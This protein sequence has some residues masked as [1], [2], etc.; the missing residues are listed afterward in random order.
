MLTHFDLVN[1]LRDVNND[2]AFYYFQTAKNL[3]AG[4]FSTFDDGITR[5]NGYH[6]LWLLLITPFYWV[7]DPEAALFGIKAFEIMLVA[8]GVAL[9]VLAA[10]I[11][12]LPWMLLFALLPLL[13]QHRALYHGLEAAAAL[14]MLGLLFLALSLFSRN[15]ARWSLLLAAV[16]FGLPW[17]RLEF[18]AIALTA[19]ASLC[20]IEWLRQ[21]KLP[22][23]YLKTLLGA[24]SGILVYFAYN[25]LVFGGFVPVSAA[26]KQAYSQERWEQAGGFSIMQN[27]QEVLQMSVFDNELL[28]A[29]EICAY[30]LLVW[31]SARRSPSRD[32]WLLLVFLVGAFSLAAGHLVKFAQTVLA[33]HP[34]WGSY[35][36]YFVPAYLMMALI[37]FVRC[38][39]AIHFIRR[40]IGARSRLVAN[41][42][43]LGIVAAGTV[44]LFVKTDF[45]HPFRYVD[46]VSDSAYREWEMT[47]YLGTQI[48]N[49]VLPEDSVIGSWHSGVI[50]YFS[51]F[52]VVN[53]DGLMNSYAYV[54]VRLRRD[55]AVKAFYRKFGITHFANVQDSKR[56]PDNL[57]FEGVSFPRSGN[58]KFELWAAEP[59]EG[60]TGELDNGAWFWERMEPHVHYKLDEIMVFVD[61]RLVQI[62]AKDCE[63]EILRD[64]LVVF[65]WTTKGSEAVA[66][67][68]FPW[69]DARKNHLG[70]CVNAFELP[71][72]V[73]HPVRVETM[74][75]SDYIER[76]IGDS[77]PIIRSSFDVYLNE[78]SL[79]YVKEQCGR[80]DIE[81]PFFLHLIPVD[82]QDLPG[83]RKQY[84]FDNLDFALRD[85]G[86][87]VGD[88]CVAVRE[89]P[90]YGIRRIR[91]GQYVPGEGRIWEGE[92]RFGE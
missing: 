12:R 54:R 66:A 86:I 35:S 52:P 4:K 39:V 89:L 53:L 37:V 9:V 6:P 63:P 14:F 92:F 73:I 33:V 67:P 8:G 70:F 90:G 76:L 7:F 85:H 41:M 62:F 48:M 47:S 43:S 80:D 77:Q 17:V 46:R 27:F 74:S 36:W 44:F 28:V 24:C 87:R 10:R 5:T 18:V 72:D 13:Y 21:K 11:C 91:T 22:F 2:D 56:K 88:R 64:K 34:Y 1:L 3:A 38:Y 15:P 25:Y 59:L 29:L 55:G 69:V 78:N 26:V 83:H 51:E 84:G 30:V 75:V 23:A 19:T 79:V 40:F 82:E 20:L 16:A 61:D 42:L 81:H 60:S 45:T 65:S 32:D 58:R 50:G 57:L 68:W 49:R 71:N 31:W